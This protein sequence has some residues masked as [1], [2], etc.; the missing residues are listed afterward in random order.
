MSMVWAISSL[1]SGLLWYAK[2]W[3][4]ETLYKA[5]VVKIL[6]VIIVLLF[7]LSVSASNIGLAFLYVC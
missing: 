3:L 5:N 7:Y 1:P 2:L 6:S 4:I